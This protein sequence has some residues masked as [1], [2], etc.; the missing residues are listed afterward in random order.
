M[1]PFGPIDKHASRKTLYL[2]IATLNI[3]FPDYDFSDVRPSHFVKED[4]GAEILKYPRS[5]PSYRNSRTPNILVLS[6]LFIRHIPPCCYF[7]IQPNSI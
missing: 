4:N 5:I 1:T 3:A 7:T 2:L 6:S